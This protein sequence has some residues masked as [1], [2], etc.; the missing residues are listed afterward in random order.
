MALDAEE[1]HGHLIRALG[2]AV[3]CVKT[4]EKMSKKK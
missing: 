2:H 1:R 3:H 4:H